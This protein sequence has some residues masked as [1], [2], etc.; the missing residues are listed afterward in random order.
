MRVSTKGQVTI[1]LSV[2]EKTGVVPGSEVEFHVEKDRI[3]IQKTT[4]EGRG[5]ALIKRMSGKGTVKM[6]TDEILHHT[7]KQ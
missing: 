3:Y 5:E 6:S 1:P 7:R 4:S 2:R